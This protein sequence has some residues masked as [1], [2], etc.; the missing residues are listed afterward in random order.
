MRCTAF[1]LLG[2]LI[3][4]NL[5]ITS[6]LPPTRRKFDIRDFITPFAEPPFL[7]LTIG[8]FII[9]LGGFLPFNFI[10]TQAK[11]EGMSTE[12]ASYMVSIVN[13]ASYVSSSST[14]SN[15]IITNR[16]LTAH[17]AVF[18]QHTLATSMASS[19]SW[20]SSPSLVASSRWPS[21]F[22]L[23]LTPPSLS[24]QSC[25]ASL[26]AVCSPLSRPWSHPSRLT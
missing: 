14:V 24:L 11:A 22:L 19:T 26:L 4:G 6:R 16:W 10:I 13:A 3:I 17:L 25:M 15:G 12:L 7:L 9:Y 21:G 1:L 20:P 2:L 5:T 8:G 18:C 23:G